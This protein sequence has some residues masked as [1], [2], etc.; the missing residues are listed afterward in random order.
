MIANQN[1]LS[2]QA[3][4]ELSSGQEEH[5]LKGFLAEPKKVKYIYY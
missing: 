3:L 1:N 2:Q 4:S 5:V